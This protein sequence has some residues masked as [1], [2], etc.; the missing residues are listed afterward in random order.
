MDRRVELA[1]PGRSDL[2]Q[3][4]DGSFHRWYSFILGYP[5]HLVRSILADFSVGSDQL[6]ADPFCGTGTTAIECSKN[7]IRSISMD[8]NPFA[9]FAART[10]CSF[11]LDPN[12]LQRAAA[13]AEERYRAILATGRDFMTDVTYL[14]LNESGMIE[15]GWISPEPLR[16]ALALRE[17]IRRGRSTQLANA[18]MLALAADLPQKIG[19]MKFGPQIYRGPTKSDVD[20]IP[21]FRARVFAM[22]ED[23]RLSKDRRNYAKA[24]V[25]LDDSRTCLSLRRNAVPIDFIICSPPYPTEH[26]YTR[27]TRLELA[28]ID[29]VSTIGCLQRI[30][31]SMI[32]S[33][34]KGLYKGDDDEL[35]CAF[36]KEIEDLASQVQL[37]VADKESGFEKLYPRVIR[38]Y[39][40]GMRRHFSGIFQYLRSGAKAAYV[41]GDQA[42]Y[43][44]IPVRTAFLLSGV[45][46]HAGFRV[47][48]IKL[49]RRR[50][51]TGI[52]GYLDENILLLEKP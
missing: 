22:I 37:A 39:F 12:S 23:L 1:H 41:V 15:R 28:F 52:S 30:K 19:N 21:L 11:S 40:G 36:S 26:D 25:L 31:K 33:H 50:W 29:S 3:F 32:R 20:P 47:R 43:M 5:D 16:R 44:R 46:E 51:S 7:Q 4:V 9:V 8:A 38:S 27:H 48:E 18:L 45:A 14:Y 24:N 49:W 35:F 2:Q 34:T 17:A 42:A 10:K 6:V 13:R